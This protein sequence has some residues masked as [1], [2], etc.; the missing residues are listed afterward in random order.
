MGKTFA[1]QESMT[2]PS[3]LEIQTIV[4]MPFEE[5]TYVLWRADRNEALV[6]DPGLEPDAIFAFLEERGLVVAAI[7]NT[8]GHADH[9]AGNEALKGRYPKAPLVIGVNEVALLSDARSNMS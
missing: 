9:I 5:N 3:A 8:H 4:S 7:L 6:V 2:M 1:C